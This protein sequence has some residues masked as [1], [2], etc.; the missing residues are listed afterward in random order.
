MA[1]QESCLMNRGTIEAPAVTIYCMDCCKLAHIPPSA[2]SLWS[3]LWLV[4]FR[5]IN[6]L[7]VCFT[8]AQN[9]LPWSYCPLNIN[10]TSYVDECEKATST[11]Y[12]WYRKTLNI[13]PSIEQSGSIQWEQA[14]CLILAWLLVYLCILRG[15]EHTGKVIIGVGL[16]VTFEK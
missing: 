12:F 10:H 13:S 4:V 2:P 11:Q 9:P 8:H 16:E 14:A 1:S 5:K 3:P 6:M 7:H 15:T